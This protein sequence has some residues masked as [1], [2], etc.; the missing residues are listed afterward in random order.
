M[1]IR[2][3]IISLFLCSLRINTRI[4]RKIEPSII[5][6]SIP[7]LR[8]SRTLVE[9]ISP[10]ISYNSMSR[11]GSVTR[12]KFDKSTRWNFYV[13]YPRDSGNLIIYGFLRRIVSFLVMYYNS[14]NT[15][16]SDD[17]LLWKYL[18]SSYFFLRS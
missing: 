2:K 3:S 12:R 9:N 10:S 15:F 8:L 11:I 1:I 6:L 14:R 13:H 7:V 16:H 18:S 17:E 4:I 5:F